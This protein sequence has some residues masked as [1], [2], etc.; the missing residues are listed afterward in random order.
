MKVKFNSQKIKAFFKKN[1]YY[2]IM[3]VCVLAIGA[4]VTVAVVVGESANTNPTPNENIAPDVNAPTPDN[5]T[6][7]VTPPDT[8]IPD[9]DVSTE[10]TPIVFALPVENASV[11][12]DYAMDTLVWSS[13][14]KQYQVHGGID[15]AGEENANVLC[16]YD[17]VVKSVSYD[18][19]SGHKV[20]VDHGNGLVTEYSSLSEPV[21]AEGQKVYKG[22]KL[23][24]ISTSST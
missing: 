23:A 14:L 15:Y 21:V 17:G 19:L 6:P 11:I 20:S 9:T 13:T 3:G 24:T 16:V 2:M 18:A 12:N 10:P 5:D 4:M 8:N 1:A 7:I 22:S